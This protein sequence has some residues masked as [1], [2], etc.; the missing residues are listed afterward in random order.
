MGRGNSAAP[1]NGYIDHDT[2]LLANKDEPL[3]IYE[4]CLIPYLIY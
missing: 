4:Y 1:N 2:D 3:V